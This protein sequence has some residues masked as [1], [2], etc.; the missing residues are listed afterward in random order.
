MQHEYY[1]GSELGFWTGLRGL[2]TKVPQGVH[3]QRHWWGFGQSAK[4][5]AWGLCPKKL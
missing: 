1:G 4:D 2:G 3:G 5:G